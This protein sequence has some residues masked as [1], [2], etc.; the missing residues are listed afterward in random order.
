[1]NLEPLSNEDVETFRILVGPDFRYLDTVVAYAQTDLVMRTLFR[2]YL[3]GPGEHRIL[4]SLTIGL[5]IAEIETGR[6]H[7]RCGGDP[8]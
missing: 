7:G 3:D 1:V 4:I 6:T 5:R 2:L 8:A